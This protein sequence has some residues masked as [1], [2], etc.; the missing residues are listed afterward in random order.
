MEPRTCFSATA[1]KAPPLPTGV[2]N[3]V[4]NYRIGSGSAGNV[5]A[6]AISTL[7]DRPLGVNAVSNPQAATG[8]H[9]A[10]TNDGIRANAPQNVL[11]L[12]RAV[13]ITD[14]Q[15]FA[16]TFAG[17]AKASAIWIPGGPARGV[18]LTVAGVNGAALPPGNPT[19]HKPGDGTPQLRQSDD[20]DPSRKP[21]SRRCSVFRRT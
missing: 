20:S 18:F 13:S 6:N 21:S 1:S 12:G 5:A 3:I 8:G 9:D 7:L 2:N 15:N 19:L 10:Q 4:A 11:T 17:I 14:Y 16:A